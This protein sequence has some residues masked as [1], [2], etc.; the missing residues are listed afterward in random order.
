MKT[1]KQQIFETIVELHS[2]ETPATIDIISDMTGLKKATVNECIK[3]LCD[4]EHIYRISKGVYAPS[5]QH[6]PARQIWKGVLPDNTV[7]VEID[8]IVLT[9]TPKEARILGSLLMAEAIECGNI[10]LSRQFAEQ[11]HTL[12]NRIKELEKLVSKPLPLFD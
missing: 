4:D 11:N 5:I 6:P 8:D 1:Q 12:H 3:D 7:K 2:K 9:L 10:A